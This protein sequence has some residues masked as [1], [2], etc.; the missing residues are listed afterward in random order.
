MNA[1]FAGGDVFGTLTIWNPEDGTMRE[2]STEEDD[3]KETSMAL[4]PGGS[5][6]ATGY[7]ST[8]RLWGFVNNPLERLA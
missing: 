3:S 5:I 1:R 8:V 4:P 7:D 2:L 6:L